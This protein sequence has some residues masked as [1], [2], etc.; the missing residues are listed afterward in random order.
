L[1]PKMQLGK[2]INCGTMT[3]HLDVMKIGSI[4]EQ[5]KGARNLLVYY[6]LWLLGD[7][8]I[9]LCFE[10]WILSSFFFTAAIVKPSAAMILQGVYHPKWSQNGFKIAMKCVA[11]IL[12]EFLP[13][14]YDLCLFRFMI[15]FALCFTMGKAQWVK[16]IP[17]MWG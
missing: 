13:I 16:D 10:T 12:M 3:K 9:F 1:W 15:N 8:F 11:N 14:P 17:K 5:G 4:F 2:N 7:I 6:R